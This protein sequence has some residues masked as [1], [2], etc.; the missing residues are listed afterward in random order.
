[1][2][3]LRVISLSTA[4]KLLNSHKHST[5]RCLYLSHHVKVLDMSRIKNVPRCIVSYPNSGSWLHD[6]GQ[7][8]YISLDVVYVDYQRLKTWFIPWLHFLSFFLMQTNS[9]KSDSPQRLMNPWPGA[10]LCVH[11]ESLWHRCTKHATFRLK[12]LFQVLGRQFENVASNA[13]QTRGL[14]FFWTFP[15]FPRIRHYY[16]LIKTLI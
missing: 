3:Y 8:T 15:M 12:I 14:R 5:E 6:P 4:S 2:Y 11:S 1:M 10:L 7:L 13:W 9:L 16:T